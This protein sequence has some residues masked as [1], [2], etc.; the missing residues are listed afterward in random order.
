MKLNELLIMTSAHNDYVDAYDEY[1]VRLGDGFLDTI[2]APV[3]L[4]EMVENENRNM[5]GKR[6]IIGSI[7]KQS[8]DL[9]LSFRLVASSRTVL[10]NNRKRFYDEVLYQSLIDIRLPKVTE[11][12][13]HLRYIG[14]NTTYGQNASGT[15]CMITAKF[16]EA[17]PAKRD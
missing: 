5:H 11:E 7:R 14:K 1:G 8:R 2:Q 13:F 17:N 9:S 10:S 15:S 4:K 16:E 6:V 3:E 12:V